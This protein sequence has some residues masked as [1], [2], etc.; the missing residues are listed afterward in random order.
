[1]I[2][3][4]VLIPIIL[5][6]SLAQLVLGEKYT[7][8]IIVEG[9]ICPFCTYGLEKTLKKMKNVSIL[10]YNVDLSTGAVSM[11]IETKRSKQD[12]QKQLKKAVET[13]AGFTLKK[14]SI[15]KGTE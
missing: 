9:M 11:K 6:F 13:D 7:V 14:S 3:K 2:Q 5:L 1:M 15:K 8:D 10:E 4:K 12:V